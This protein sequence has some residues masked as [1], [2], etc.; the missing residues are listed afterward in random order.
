M[1]IEQ[2]NKLLNEFKQNH[3]MYGYEH[4]GNIDEAVDMAI[5]ALSADG[6]LISRKAVLKLRKYNLYGGIHTVNVADIEKLPTIPQTDSET[7]YW[8]ER[9][10]SYERT[11]V[12]L[13]KGIAETDTDSVLEDIKAEINQTRILHN[14]SGIGYGLDI[15]LGVIDKHISR[16]ENE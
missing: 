12:A 9:A 8:K 11:I 3:T 13:Q 16:K 4:S 5:S 6:D 10:K 14:N 7:E 1:T 2:A 15:A